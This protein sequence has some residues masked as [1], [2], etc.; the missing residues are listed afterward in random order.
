[1]T[2]DLQAIGLQTR[3]QS[4]T[5]CGAPTYGESRPPLGAGMPWWRSTHAILTATSGL[6]AGFGLLVG[7]SSPEGWAVI[8]Y[9]LAIA[10][11]AYLP[12]SSALKAL[13]VRQV[14]MNVLMTIAAAG[15][16]TVGEWAEGA[17]VVFLFALGELLETF[18]LE[19]T[20]NAVRALMDLSP[21]VAEVKRG[22]GT[23][24]VTA[25]SVS[26][27]QVVVVRPGAR[28][29]VDG[30]VLQGT[31]AV[32]Q[33]PITGEA[34]PVDKRPGD[35]VFAG[36]ISH[37]GYLE[38]VCRRVAADTTLARII[39]LVEKAQG[40]RAPSQRF[41]DRFAATYTPAVVATAMAI[42]VG[43]PLFL[44]QPWY[45]WLYRGLALLILA[46]PCAMVISTPVAIVTA[47]GEAARRGILVKGGASLEALAAVRVV[48]VDKTGTLTEGAL[49]LTG[50]AAAS[51]VTEAD[52]L[53]LAA[54]LEAL[55]EHPIA[56]AVVA[57]AADR[58]LT[59]A[60][61]SELTVVGGKGVHGRVD[62]LQ[63]TLGSARYLQEIGVDPA[64]LDRLMARLGTEGN[65]VVF[66][67]AP[68]RVL[69][70]L[71]LSDLPRPG[72]NHALQRLR[73]LGVQRVVML[74]G[75]NPVA[76]DAIGREVGVDEVRAGLLPE[77]KLAVVAELE[78]NWGPAAM[79]GD[80][81]NDA[82]ALARASVGVAM[83]VAGTDAAL[84]TADVALM[85]DRLDRL[86]EGIWLSRQA[87]RV[88]RQNLVFA[89]V[90]K[91][92]A[93]AALIP[94]WLTLWMAIVA[95]VGAS[96]AVIGNSLRLRSRRALSASDGQS[97]PIKQLAG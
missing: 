15:A 74:T 49:R 13:R 38:V 54:G 94:G 61:A 62:G 95:D 82:P 20:R 70:A 46:C 22:D 26:P 88:V 29:P 9:A 21:S 34:A 5:P 68:G 84:E 4:D 12:V 67:T 1:M 65:T 86:P 10:T 64:E 83:G 69:G 44:G 19:R 51:G 48:L 2:D 30:V 56:R 73:R 71:A 81:V 33:A 92:L 7:G 14:D 77:D 80:G 45:P 93:L 52:V 75:D 28:I 37:D 47:I 76:A 31:A 18:A 97:L 57:A 24:V 40:S 79:V 27:G 41:I 17:L 72:A 36:T 32:N 59:V 66:I 60:R 63:L 58:G 16:V 3:C 55:A 42:V 11:G 78:A 85:G 53:A 87:L 25:D 6:L 8:P 50:V 43:P 35:P 90:T 39:H 96:L 91:A 23:E 89:L